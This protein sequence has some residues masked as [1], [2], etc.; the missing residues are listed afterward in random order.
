MRLQSA[1]NPTR[2]FRCC[3]LAEIM[4]R[5]RS[6][7]RPKPAA[8]TRAR[9]RGA[10]G[11]IKPG[12]KRGFAS[13]TPGS[14][15]KKAAS[16]RSGRQ[17]NSI[18]CCRPLRELQYVFGFVILGLAP[19]ALCFRPLRGLERFSYSR[20]WGWRPRLYAFARFA[21]FDK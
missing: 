9:A 8:E 7:T 21:S 13:A 10:G 19:Q 3:Q 12:V 2:D 1:A 4:T 18:T 15:N 11:S 20:S 14:Q 17:P 6:G 5:A 16:P